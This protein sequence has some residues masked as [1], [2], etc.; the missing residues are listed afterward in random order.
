MKALV[1][2]ISQVLPAQWYLAG[3]T[4]LAL[5][6]GHRASIDL[7]YFSTTKF[8]VEELKNQLAQLWSAR[9]VLI[10]YEAPQTLWYE[11]DGVQV[12]FIYRRTPL[13]QPVY[14]ENN[15]RLATLRDITVMKLLAICS[16]EEYKDYFDLACL[17]QQTD[18]RSW[19]HWWEDAY[20]EQ[21][22]T[23]W[24]MALGNYDTVLEIPLHVT[25]E[26]TKLSV[27]PQLRT[28]CSELTAY[29]QSRL[30]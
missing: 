6:I 15:W 30:S 26:F 13:L 11:V 17:S 9:A 1:N 18:V 16:R 24:L 10:T 7:D 29:V 3:D 20:P 5:H 8:L 19:V 14:E 2:E 28:V 27:A 21:D 22:I 23:S 25:A 12:S 4:A